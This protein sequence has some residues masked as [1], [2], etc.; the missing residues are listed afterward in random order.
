MQNEHQSEMMELEGA[1][2]APKDGQT[3]ESMTSSKAPILLPVLRSTGPRTKEGKARS[4]HN[5]IKHAI[6]S[7]VIVLPGESRAE[8]NA[9]LNDLTEDRHPEGRLEEILV[10]KLAAIIWRQRRLF[11][12]EGAEI[13]KGTEFCEFDKAAQ[14]HE[15][16][17]RAIQS[18]SLTETQ[19]PQVLDHCLQLLGELRDG[20]DSEFDKETNLE[21]LKKLYGCKSQLRETLIPVYQL[22]CDHW[23]QLSTGAI[24]EEEMEHQGRPTRQDCKE[25]MLF[26]IDREIRFLKQRRKQCQSL[27]SARTKL[28]IQRLNVPA[29]SGLDRLVRYEGHLGKEFDRTFSQLERVQRLRRG[30]PVTPRLDIT[31]S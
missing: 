9:L 30:Q 1:S 25:N 29:S 15:E 21:I 16:A 5:A 18:E 4:K 19:N 27:E 12:A 11:I 28:E 26:L 17:E 31:V 10:E 3:A 6:F 24:S 2:A 20:I 13:R 22:V 8:Y 14:D 23:T 7:R